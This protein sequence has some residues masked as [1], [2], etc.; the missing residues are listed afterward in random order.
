[1]LLFSIA[2]SL[3]DPWKFLCYIFWCF[4][5]MLSEFL[6]LLLDFRAGG[7]ET[8]ETDAHIPIHV[9][10]LMSYSQ[11]NYCSL[12]FKWGFKPLCCLKLPGQEGESLICPLGSSYLDVASTPGNADLFVNMGHV[13]ST[14]IISVLCIT[15]LRDCFLCITK[16]KP[17]VSLMYLLN[18]FVPCKLQ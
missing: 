8:E 14:N 12:F 16:F 2:V 4:S 13:K 11:K 17:S 5:I 7:G 18:E 6:L 9:V 10:S 3:W 15:V 1:M